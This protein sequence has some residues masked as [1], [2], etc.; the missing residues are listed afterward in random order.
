MIYENMREILEDA[1]ELLGALFEH[2]LTNAAA[3]SDELCGHREA[4]DGVG[5]NRGGELLADLADELAATRLSANNNS[6]KSAALLIESW[7]YIAACL[8][9][10]D[11]VQAGDSGDV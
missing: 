10:L 5:L 11:F 3:I 4:F 8:Y 1:R 6:E 7:R 2:G 9:R